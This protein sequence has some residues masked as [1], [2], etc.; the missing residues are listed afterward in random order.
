MH[1][2]AR[3][4]QPQPQPLCCCLALLAIVLAASAAPVELSSSA[5][6]FYNGDLAPDAALGGSSPCELYVKRAA[7]HGGARIQLV[8]THYWCASCGLA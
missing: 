7:S 5:L 2:D 1:V 8:P 3:M 4:R 6:M